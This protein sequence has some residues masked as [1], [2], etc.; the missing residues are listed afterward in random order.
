MAVGWRSAYAAGMGSTLHAL[1][2]RTSVPD[3]L[4]RFW[5]ELL[6]GEREN[7][8]LSSAG[9][10]PMRLAFVQSDVPKGGLNQM[11]FHLTSNA[12][13]QDETV[14]RALELGAT[15]LDAGQLPDEDHVVLAD[16]DGNEFCVIEAG[17]NWLA[18]TGFFGELA[19][20]GTREVGVFWSE[21][22][23]WPLVHDEDG[24]TAISPPAGGFKIAW[25]GE[26]LNERQPPN[27]MYF[28][29]A[30]DDLEAEIGRLETLGATRVE[31]RGDEVEMA[32]PDGNAFV[33]RG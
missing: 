31:R 8:V 21:A 18:G 25:G 17:N 29:L 15:H 20:D 6:G 4:A 3:P 22:L 24:E 19:A 10:A 5:G 23:G 28:V 16:P 7:L 2:I 9:E 33:V 12:A 26:P 13:A 30:A 11:H 27:R 1:T 14:A 32:D